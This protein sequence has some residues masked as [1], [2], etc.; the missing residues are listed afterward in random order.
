MEIHCIIRSLDSRSSLHHGLSL[1]V[2]NCSDCHS[3]A[4]L[5]IFMGYFYIALQSVAQT[6]HNHSKTQ[7]LKLRVYIPSSH[8]SLPPWLGRILEQ[9][10]PI[11]LQ[12]SISNDYSGTLL[13]CYIKP[14]WLTACGAV[15][16]PII[17]SSTFA[18]MEAQRLKRCRLPCLHPGFQPSFES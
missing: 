15:V 11:W 7:Q 18:V 14:F 13:V 3:G 12:A 8:P 9:R 5:D 16:R 2:P 17:F 4:C 10:A 1:F 6:S